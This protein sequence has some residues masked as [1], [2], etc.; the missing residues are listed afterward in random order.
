MEWDRVFS[1]LGS[2]PKVIRPRDMQRHD[3]Q[4]HHGEQNEAASRSATAKRFNVGLSTENPHNQVID[5]PTTGM[6]ENRLVITVCAPE[7]HLPG[8]TQPIKRRHHDQQ[9]DHTED[10]QQFLLTSLCGTHR[11]YAEDMN[12]NDDKEHRRAVGMQITQ[13]HMTSRVDRVKGVIG[14]TAYNSSRE[15]PGHDHNHQHDQ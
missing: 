10:P 5:W 1:L 12:I 14:Q 15:Q 2:I 8:R 13:Q 9:N 3:V 4:K 6:A 11:M 7:A